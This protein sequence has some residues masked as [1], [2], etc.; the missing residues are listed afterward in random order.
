MKKITFI[1]FALT[2][3]VANAPASADDINF[4]GLKTPR[5]L[6]SPL[7]Q[8]YNFDSNSY[9]K[10][11]SLGIHYASPD[12]HA[13]FEPISLGGFSQTAHE[14][15]DAVSIL[16]CSG[17]RTTKEERFSKNYCNM[18]E[19]CASSKK[20]NNFLGPMSIP[21]LISEEVAAYKLESTISRLE[22]IEK[23]RKFAEKKYGAKFSDACPSPF[24]F[25]SANKE[26]LKKSCDMSIVEKAF[27]KIQ[28]N[29]KNN[30]SCYSSSNNSSKDFKDYAKNFKLD[31][32]NPQS[33]INSFFKEKTD[34]DITNVLANDTAMI[35][36]LANIL[37][38]KDSPADKQKN[39]IAKLREFKRDNKLDPV[40]ANTIKWIDLHNHEV[41]SQ[42]LEF[43]N[44]KD[45]TLERAK[46]FL[47]NTRKEIAEQT[48]N[49]FC[50]NQKS[51]VAICNEATE[52]K[53][54]KKLCGLKDAKNIADF[55]K[56]T[57]PNHEGYS[58][59]YNSGYKD[60]SDFGI[61]LEAQ[62]CRALGV[63][64]P[65]YNNFSFYDTNKKVDA[66][67]FM[68]SSE[69]T[70]CEDGT[71]TKEIEEEAETTKEFEKGN[72]KISSSNVKTSIMSYDSSFG[73]S[74]IT[75]QS[76]KN[77]S[78]KDIAIS[79]ASD[80][81]DYASTVSEDLAKTAN[82]N[83]ASNSSSTNANNIPGIIKPSTTFITP[84]AVNNVIDNAAVS[85]P[86]IEDKASSSLSEKVSELTQKLSDAENNIEKMKADKKA[87]DL[88]IENQKKMDEENKTIADLKTQISNL[89]NE[90]SNA[91]NNNA[92]A[93]QNKVEPSV[94]FNNWT[95]NNQ[96]YDKYNNN[97]NPNNDS[98]QASNV[99]NSAMTSGASIESAA[100]AGRVSSSASGGSNS[101]S[102][103]SKSALVLTKVDG[104]TTEKVA[105]TIYDKIK[106]SNGAPFLIEEGG[107]VKEI[108][109]LIKNGKVL[110]DD[111]GKPMYEKIIKGKVGEGKYAVT[112]QKKTK[113]VAPIESK[114][115]LLHDQEEKLK[116]ERA[117]YLKLKKITTDIFVTK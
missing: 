78:D 30:D 65:N 64:D 67:T 44:L 71:K 107:M 34:D 55:L 96:N 25:D 69:S 21:S 60:S 37:I 45:L 87:A 103:N 12:C 92:S 40:F 90:K 66:T 109:P 115:D 50:P 73:T 8:K 35:E 29:C 113:V 13:N 112:E 101:A 74:N 20:A 32:K 98:K 105:E 84:D 68:F 82:E 19:Q 100:G 17:V 89:K 75:N 91:S 62:R 15:I 72:I 57:Y 85:S 58:I 42:F 70:G 14:S 16:Q 52:I 31:D 54:N 10:P 28:E 53:N 117:E 110:V 83:S 7:L 81:N 86:K 41:S 27:S 114:A 23:L 108:I 6:S 24:N 47:E 1:I 26:E 9:L 36:T 61:V 49:K 48:L 97:N 99:S 79:S 116:R 5:T 18:Y 104:L 43:C 76:S 3:V 93:M 46:A 56:S 63:T 94:P 39:L 2:Y 59:S 111:S 77:Q 51:L 11:I 102:A 38:S 33:L 88:D 106:E 95:N 22:N 80:R 4:L